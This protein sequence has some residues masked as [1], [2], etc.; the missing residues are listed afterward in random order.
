[1]SYLNGVK[2]ISFYFMGYN[3]GGFISKFFP[4][5]EFTKIF[6]SYVLFKR[7]YSFILSFILV[8]HSE[9][10]LHRSEL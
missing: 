8:I 7:F 4:S 5:P 1:M 3:F 10:I 6:F 9:L 2:I